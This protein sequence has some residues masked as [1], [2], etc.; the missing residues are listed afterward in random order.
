MSAINYELLVSELIKPLTTHPEE[1]KVTVVSEEGN[2]I[3]VKVTTNPADTGRVIGRKGR[4]AN[5]LRT[6]GHAAAMRHQEY[7]DISFDSEVEESEE[8]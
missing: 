1:V 6:I 4:V 2:T 5:A 3:K 7:L 8:E